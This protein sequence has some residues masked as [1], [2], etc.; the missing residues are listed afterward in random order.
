MAKKILRLKKQCRQKNSRV[1]KNAR[2]KYYHLLGEVSDDGGEV[3]SPEGE[4]PLVG[5][6]SLHAVANSSVA[7]VQSALL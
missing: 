1:E 7:S 3:A 6:R 2:K 5:Q 4:H